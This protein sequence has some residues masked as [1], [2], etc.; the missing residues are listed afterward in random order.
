[1]HFTLKAG[2]GWLYEGRFV[3]DS[4]SAEQTLL[5][6]VS[7]QR[8]RMKYKVYGICTPA[9]ASICLE[10]DYLAPPPHAAPQQGSHVPAEYITM[11]SGLR[12][13]N[14]QGQDLQPLSCGP[15]PLVLPTQSLI[16]PS[17]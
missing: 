12:G 8:V 14:S 17:G 6:G 11:D 13:Q 10:H 4:Q 3:K 1:M 2:L 5:N 16:R 15:S 7:A 9:L